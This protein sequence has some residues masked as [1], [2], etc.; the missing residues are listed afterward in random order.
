LTV[1]EF[2]PRPQ[3]PIAGSSPATT[4]FYDF[5]IRLSESVGDSASPEI[6]AEI[7][8][9][10]QA[11]EESGSGTLQ[12]LVSVRVEG[13]LSNGFAS[14]SLVNDSG[15]PESF[16]YYGTDTDG[17]KGWHP[18]SDT[19]D[20]EDGVQKTVTPEGVAVLSPEG[21]LAAAYAIST[22][23]FVVRVD[24]TDWQTRTLASSGDIEITD[25]GTT[26][27]I[28]VDAYPPELGYGGV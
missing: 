25:D 5:L 23:G 7:N 3:S 15:S 18:A 1:R 4:E 21:N 13:N 12:G 27:T 11:L 10:I 20:A 17:A 2:L 19:V 14:V 28:G 22:A 26:V 8:A 16:S 24:D 6:I 9:R